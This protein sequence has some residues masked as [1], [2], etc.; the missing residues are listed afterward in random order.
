[1]LVIMVTSLIIVYGLAVA[2]M[3]IDETSAGASWLAASKSRTFVSACIDNAL[4][5]LRNDNTTSGNVN[6][7][8]SNV[9]CIATIS[10][11]GTTRQITGNATST[12]P[13]ARDIVDRVNVNVNINTNPFTILQYKDILQ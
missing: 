6:I 2:L 8:T 11:S 7:T 13:Y 9:N 1:M 12:D 5:T 10:G 4:S 3:S